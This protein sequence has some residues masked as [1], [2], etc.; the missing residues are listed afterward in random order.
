MEFLNS[1]EVKNITAHIECQWGSTLSKDWALLQRKDGRISIVNRSI[2][3]LDLPTLP[4]M[5]LGLYIGEWKNDELRLSIEGTQLLGPSA[6]KNVVKISPDQL[7]EWLQGEDI[8]F[9]GEEKGF[10]ILKSGKDF[11]GCG[12]VVENKI[13]NFVPKIRRLSVVA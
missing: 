12:K 5:S 6:T 4:I 11:V 8:S 13:L 1:R 3:R 10:V 7:R 2:D 9:E